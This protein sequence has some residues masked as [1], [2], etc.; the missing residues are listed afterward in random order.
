M[1]VFEA[2]AFAT[3]RYKELA[4]SFPNPEYRINHIIKELR[5]KHKFDTLTFSVHHGGH[6]RVKEI[7][8]PKSTNGNMMCYNFY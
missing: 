6:V 8:F 7:E 5:V 3:K 4:E 1:E 2:R